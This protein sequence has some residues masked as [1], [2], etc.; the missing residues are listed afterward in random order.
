MHGLSAIA[1]K[2]SDTA[3]IVSWDGPPVVHSELLDIY[4]VMVTNYSLALVAN[5]TVSRD[6]TSTTVTGLGEERYSIHIAGNF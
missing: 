5:L 4:Y 1:P 2:D 6:T 3:L